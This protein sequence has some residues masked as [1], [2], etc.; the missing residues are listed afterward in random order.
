MFYT[1]RIF[2]CFN[3]T[4]E[5]LPS[6]KLSILNDKSEVV[7]RP[8]VGPYFEGDTVTVTCL[9]HGGNPLPSL[10]WWVDN[11]VVDDTDEIVSG[12]Q[13]KNEMILR[14]LSREHVGLV[15]TC[16]AVN[17]DALPPLK[18]DVRLDM[19]RK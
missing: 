13:V 7:T 1:V 9:S 16:Q 17:T 8:L 5:N 6:S 3:R 19:Y 4:R 11:S 15:Y 18:A 14:D 12:D 2:P 10:T